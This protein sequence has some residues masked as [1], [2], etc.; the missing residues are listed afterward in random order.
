MPQRTPPP[1]RPSGAT[2]KLVNMPEIVQFHNAG[3]ECIVTNSGTISAPFLRYEVR[4]YPPSIEL[5]A[6]YEDG[7]TRTFYTR[8]VP[9]AQ[10]VAARSIRDPGV[11]TGITA[12][13]LVAGPIQKRL[14]FRI[15]H[16][17]SFHPAY[18]AQLRVRERHGDRVVLELAVAV[19]ALE[20]VRNLRAQG[21]A[22]WTEAEAGPAPMTQGPLLPVPRGVIP[23]TPKTRDRSW[24]GP[25]IPLALDGGGGYARGT[26]ATTIE[27]YPGFHKDDQ[28]NPVR[29]EATVWA[30]S[31]EHLGCPVETFW[32]RISV[33]H[34]EP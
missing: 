13:L 29:V 24:R 27:D 11:E 7:H 3:R 21:F 20:H 32:S 25:V 4:N 15:P 6:E 23:V 34:L 10:A 19:G 5:R 9:G 18:A 26:L 8:N 2:P 22:R 28:G 17:A 30:D 16:R 1:S 31:D 14:P 33:P 12:Y